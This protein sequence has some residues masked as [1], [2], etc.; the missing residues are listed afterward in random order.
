MS[1]QFNMACPSCGGTDELDVVVAVWARLTQDGTD[2]C[3]AHDGGAHRWDAQSPC[4]CE[5]CGWVGKVEEAQ[6]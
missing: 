1:N 6:P 3:E 4:R 2:D 5:T